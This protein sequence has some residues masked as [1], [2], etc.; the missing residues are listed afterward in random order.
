MGTYTA[1]VMRTAG[2]A[3][4]PEERPIPEPGQGEALVRLRATS[5]NYHDLVNLRGVIRGPWP[6]VPMSD[7][8]GEV[9]ALGPGVAHL[10]VGQ[11]V[12]LPFSPLWLS[13]PPSWDRPVEVLGDTSDGCLQQYRCMAAIALVPVPDSLS[14]AEA[15]T[16]PCAGVTA[17]SSL[18]AGAL[19]PGDV[20][21]VQGT[22]GVSMLALQLAK[23]HGATVI[24]TS[25]SDDKLKVATALG[26][27]HV[28]NYRT[29]PDWHVATREMTGGRGADIV[30]DV[31]GAGTIAKS[32]KAT[33]AGGT[34]AIVGGLEGFTNC[35]VPLAQVLM[36]Q[37]RLV[38]IAV[39]SVADH[40]D[41]CRAVEANGIHP[42]ISHTFAWNR[43][44]EAVRVQQAN[45]HVGKITV[46]IP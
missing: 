39:G 18:R 44:D 12:N 26:A 14:F 31:G 36:Q 28:V 37:I 22:G 29:T 27:D 33:T 24:A 1:M 9:V 7:G 6:R 10:A 21:L 16:L 19:E 5:M 46:L 34:I 23:A 43:L 3:P 15:A 20:V 30:I 13:G 42:H 38:G 45:E 41:L 17:W 2:S 8:T 35:D 40:R 25:S 4:E 11:R 32:V